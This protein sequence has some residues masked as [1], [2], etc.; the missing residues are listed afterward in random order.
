MRHNQQDYSSVAELASCGF[1]RGARL[2][3][4]A[5]THMAATSAAIRNEV[6]WTTR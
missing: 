2:D 3:R 1:V 5:Q 6:S 4:G